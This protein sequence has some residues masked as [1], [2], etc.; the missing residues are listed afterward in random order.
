MLT[1][2]FSIQVHAA[3]D[4]TAAPAGWAG[5]SLSA[6]VVLASFCLPADGADAPAYDV[7][8]RGGQVY[9]GDGSPP[10]RGD[11]AIRGDT[12]ARI[13]DEPDASAARVI[14]ARGLAVAPGFV[15]M[16]SWSTESLIADGNSPSE[17]RQGVTTQIFGEGQSMGPLTPAMKRRRKAQQS[18]I[19][20]NYEWNTLAEYLAY[21]ERRGVAQN[22]ASFIG[23]GTIREHVIGLAN[24]P[25]TPAE[26]ERMEQLVEQEMKAGALGVGSALIYPPGSYASSDELIALCRVAARYDG[27]YISHIRN[28]GSRFVEA[29]EELIRISRAAGIPAEIYHIGAAGAENWPKMDRVVQLVEA[30][31][32][33]G[34]R[35]TADMHA[36]PAGC[37]GLTAC[38]PPWA[39]EGGGDAMLKNLRDPATRR[40][41]ARAIRDDDGDWDNP[42]RSVGSPDHILLVQF[43]N[44]ALERYRGKTLAE[45]AAARGRDPIETLMDLILEDRSR[46]E[47][48]YF[49]DTEANVRKQIAIPWISFGSDAASMSADGVFKGYGTHPRAFG[50][51]AR[52]L[53]KYVR[54]EGVI[55]WQA[56]I[57]RMSGLPAENLGLDRR[58]LLRAGYF[59]DVVVFDPATIAD[60]ATFEDPRQYAVG[61]RHVLVNGVSV[62]ADGAPTGALP[63]R[64]IRGRGEPAR[65]A[66]A[67]APAAA[68]AAQGEDP[69]RTARIALVREAL[70]RAEPPIQNPRVL[71]AMR[72]TP[73]HLFVPQQYRKYAYADTVLPI[74]H[75]QTI[76]P[77]YIVAYMTEKIDPQPADRVLEIGT[78]SG[79]QAA[80]LSSLVQE[81]YTIEIVEPLGRRAA[82]TLKRN[83]YANVFVKIGD[84][85]E[86][87]PEKA[88]FDKIIVTCS[89]DHVPQPLVDQLRDR[90]KMIIPVGERYQQSFY[91]MEKRGGELH[92]ERLLGTFFV[93][94]TGEAE[95]QRRDN[96]D[97][98]RPSIVNGGFEAGQDAEGGP[99]SWYYQRGVTLAQQGAPEGKHYVLYAND[100]PGHLSHSNQGF[101]IDGR[102]IEALE[103]SLWVKTEGVR[104][105][106]KPENV[107]CVSI[108]FFDRNRSLAGVF[109]SG[110]YLGTREWTRVR[111]RVAV[112]RTA[113]DAVVMIGLQG[114][115]GRAAFDDI[116]ITPAPRAAK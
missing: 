40:R 36:Y 18:L 80:V 53:G 103:L 90:G 78:G 100:D 23:A 17:I 26:L 75:Q 102:R 27:M 1:R 93:P 114:A 66:V 24:R 13:A 10:L 59:A 60:R 44:P 34:L 68:A 58:G 19:R 97:G 63:G 77:P 89:P 106:P 3:R 15:N 51:F 41:I 110:P 32:R 62:L 73:R 29:V 67:A 92:R 70:E 96:P 109:R 52:V 11:V 94:M 99:E 69:Y 85:Y 76:S 57:H 98:T 6:L 28:Q 111:E 2:L 8:I 49:T 91:L 39:Q 35:I 47:A 82:E 12:I 4:R 30:A 20:F 48:V 115:T 74:G 5:R 113:Q 65:A 55:S 21:L 56:A 25:A 79:Y 87:W 95:R 50:N 83:G 9:V 116:Q 38:L 14:D 54:D 7:L 22:V 107:A 108:S 101:A 46:I 112:P 81:V 42:Y 88:P 37:T 33:D 71:D 45:I 16:L 86:G 43:Q 84:G 64:A 61:V 104:A 72:S 105:G 31:R